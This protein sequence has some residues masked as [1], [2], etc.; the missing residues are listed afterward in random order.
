M[1]FEPE[2]KIFDDRT[3]A[4]NPASKVG[5]YPHQVLQKIAFP[6][7]IKNVIIKN[8]Y[9]AYKE[10]AAISKLTA[11]VF[12]KNITA[13]I[14]NVT[15]IESL[16]S[17]NN[18]LVLNANASFMGVSNMQTTWQLPL[19]TK[20]G[21]FTVSGNAGGFNATILNPITIPLGMVSIRTGKINKVSF[22]LTGNDHV[23]KGASTFLYENLKI[24]ILKND[25]IDNNKKKG[26]ESFV[27]NLF[28]KDNNPQN[29]VLRKNVINQ[30]RD[31]SKSFFTCY[32]KVFLP[33]QKKSVI[34]K[35][36][37]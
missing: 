14:S 26:V 20:N 30:E 36:T 34:G 1:V 8:G 2:I 25:L 22:E 13:T 32:G 4:P 9:V 10:K 15:N 23:A 5:S 31:I 19:D 37:D 3:V 17:K 27:A 6:V 21:A 7:N 12:F 28:A 16:I 18:L 11:T 29:G 35:S 33:Q 24:D